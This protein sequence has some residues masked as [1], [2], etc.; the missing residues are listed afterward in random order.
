MDKKMLN[1]KLMSLWCFLQK[2]YRH[3]FTTPK[4]VVFGT[5]RHLIGLIV[6]YYSKDLTYLDGTLWEHRHGCETEIQTL[7]NN[8]Y[9]M[10]ARRP[11]TVSCLK[12]CRTKWDE[13]AQSFDERAKIF[14]DSF[15]L[16]P[17]I[18]HPFCSLAL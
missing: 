11:A 14:L 1:K 6:K 16:R 5:E 3:V 8:F 17:Q 10:F 9:K 18:W 13:G 4:H 15:R 12:H 2:H 7:N